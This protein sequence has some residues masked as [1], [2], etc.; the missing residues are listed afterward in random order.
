MTPT[1][2]P[3]AQRL[4]DMAETH[5]RL[6]RGKTLP[7]APEIA[8]EFAQFVVAGLA[9]PKRTPASARSSA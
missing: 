7:Q 4:H 8:A 1:Y 6:I 9:K 3:A 5:A 2:A